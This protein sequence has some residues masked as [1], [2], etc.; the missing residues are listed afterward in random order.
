MFI[1]LFTIA[2]ATLCFAAPAVADCQEELNNL[3]Q[4]T[5]SAETG[6]ATDNSGMPATKHQEEVLSGKQQGSG[7]EVTGSTTGTVEA[8][9]PHQKQVTDQPSGSQTEKIGQ[10]MAEAGKM[11]NA[12]D[13]QGCMNK[14]SELKNLMGIK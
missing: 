14:V 8:I 12:G 9:S 7:T 4:A 13:E 1:R 10:L 6:A 5:V 2:A 11:A 3:K